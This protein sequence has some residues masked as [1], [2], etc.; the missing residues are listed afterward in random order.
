MNSGTTSPRVASGLTNGTNYT[1]RI[2]AVNAAGAGP[3]S[4]TLNDT[5]TLT[6]Q[7]FTV[8]SAPSA[9]TVSIGTGSNTIDTFSWSAPSNNGRTITKYGY[10]TTTNNGSSWSAESET[11]NLSYAIQTAYTSS[12]YKLRVRAYNA[13][14]WGDYSNISTNGTGAWS[15]G[16]MTD[17]G[18]CASFSCSCGSCN[19]GSNTGSNTTATGTRTCYRWTRS[20]SDSGPLR[21][22]NDTGSCSTAYSNCTGGTCSSCSGCTE[23]SYI[24]TEGTYNGI[25]YYSIYDNTFTTYMARS[26]DTC[27]ACYENMYEIWYCSV[28]SSYRIVDVGCKCIGGPK[29]CC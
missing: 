7:P 25:Y 23:E 18:T 27:G 14:G 5:S 26:G 13:G 15:F 20:G 2:R 28:T 10:Q 24:T 12:S 21:N 29:Q 6:T 22:S 16:S 17:S 4:N 11:T 8:P 9:P 19:C 1:I 3:S